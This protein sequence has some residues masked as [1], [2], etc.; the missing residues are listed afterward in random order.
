MT[1]QIFSDAWH[2]V[3]ELQLEL[4]PDAQYVKQWYRGEKWYVLEDRFAGRFSRVTPEAFAFI[5]SLK[6]D[7]TVGQVWQTALAQDPATTPTQEEVVQLL[8]QLQAFN[9]L[10]VRNRSESAHIFERLEN[11]RSRKLRSKLISFLFVQIPLWNPEPLLKRLGK[12]PDRVFNRFTFVVWLILGVLAGRAVLQNLPA[13]KDQAQG[14]LAVSHL[15]YLYLCIAAL[16]LLHEGGHA[17][18]TKKF[19]G[20]VTR[21]GI[22]LLVFTPL[23]Y[24]DATS[25][26][27]FRE[28]R[29]RILV[30]AAGMLVELGCAFIAA[31]VWANTG[32]GLV[33][34][35][36]FNVMLIGS[37]SS[38]FFNGNPLLKFDSYYMLSDWLEIPN[39]YE[40][41]R[42]QWRSWLEKYVFRVGTRAIEAGAEVKEQA[43]LGLYG[44]LSLGYR[45]LITISIA[46]FIADKWFLLGVLLVALAL[47]TW[48][49]KPSYTYTKYLWNEPALRH[50]RLRALALTVAFA[51]TLLVG[52][53]YVPFT[54]AVR[55][56][57]VALA[58]ERAHV[59]SPVAGVIESI[60]TETGAFVEENDVLVEVGSQ[61]MEFELAKTIGQLDEIEALITQ[62]IGE[63]SGEM[64]PLRERQRSLRERRDLLQKRLDEAVVRA[65]ISGYV[66]TDDLAQRLSTEVDLRGALI[67][68]VNPREFEFV[69]VVSQDAAYELFH[70]E[71]LGGEI[72]LLGR[73]D[74]TIPVSS[75]EVIPFE[76]SIL[77]SAALGWKGGGDIGVQAD[78]PHG[79]LAM[80]SF[81]KVVARIP[82]DEAWG[83]LFHHNKRGILRIEL[84]SEPLG[85]QVL[86][87]VRQLLQRRYRI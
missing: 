14:V 37:V 20:T 22:M 61:D 58:V 68:L 35:T 52:L 82:R 84:E 24:L 48:V 23:P 32:G 73:A 13:L 83:H 76:Q 2:A 59:F 8:S 42:V 66:V 34:A 49:L 81:F 40:R 26:W 1:E 77:P 55:A 36:A 79:V 71:R 9:L 43:W 28:K 27:T 44:A 75:L 64:A 29:E 30:G 38:L 57:G 25:S 31:L 33:H 85:E 74:Q 11:Q 10:R 3:S 41:A 18:M 21:M 45:I 70:Y 39:L 50:V 87:S 56:P 69:A 65:P 16:K 15:P 51:T 17:L 62:S 67:T 12:W 46:L 80:E 19:G 78:D 54:R 5:T 63:R 53:Y 72:K 47:F 7:T 4:A 86:R 6:L 60:Q